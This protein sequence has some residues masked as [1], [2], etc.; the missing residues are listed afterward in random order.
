ML[1]F[2]KEKGIKIFLLSMDKYKNQV[3]EAVK[4]PE[5]DFDLPAILNLKG[6]SKI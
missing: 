4:K 5:A 3:V 1:K 6:W 2:F